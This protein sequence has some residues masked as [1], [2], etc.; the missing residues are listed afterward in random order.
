MS[1]FECHEKTPL[2]INVN[3]LETLRHAKVFIRIIRKKE[4]LEAVTGF[5]R[6]DYEKFYTLKENF[7]PKIFKNVFTKNPKNKDGKK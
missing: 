2:R 1:K 7:I 4:K 3:S 5:V 6:I